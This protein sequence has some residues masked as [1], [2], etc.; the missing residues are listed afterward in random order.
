VL[1]GEVVPPFF[2][3]FKIMSTGSNHL[4][5]GLILLQENPNC[6][7]D[8][9]GGEMH[10]WLYYQAPGED[11]VKQR[12]LLDWEIM[13]AEDQRDESIVLQGPLGQNRYYTYK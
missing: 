4:S 11:W 3:L 7:V 9:S 12:K 13:Q 6:A 8:L 10:G 5:N 1:R 2:F